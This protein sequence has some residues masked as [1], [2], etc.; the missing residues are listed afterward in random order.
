MV[1]H[2]PCAYLLTNKR[3]SEADCAEARG[4]KLAWPA[5][6]SS[7]TSALI[8]RRYYVEKAREPGPFR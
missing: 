7:G 8:L 4:G 5:R 3:E 1:L 2:R 6:A